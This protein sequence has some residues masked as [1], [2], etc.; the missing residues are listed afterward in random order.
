MLRIVAVHFPLFIL[1]A[2]GG[3]GGGG[4]GGATGPTVSTGSFPLRAGHSALTSAGA[5]DNFTVSGTCAGTS[6]IT[7]SPATPANFEGIAGFAATTTATINFTNCT[8]ASSA[9]SSVTFYDVNYTVLGSSTPGQEYS[10]FQTLPPPLPAS[11]RV[12]D[13]A[14][15]GTLIRYTDSSKAVITGTTLRSYVVEPD[16]ADTAVINFIAKDYN[17][18]SQLLFTQQT[19]YRIFATGTLTVLSIDIQFTTT[20]TTHLVLTKS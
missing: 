19:R 1:I 15:Y 2:C 8:P 6:T 4:G 14:T 18:A 3:G 20:S 17:N 7:D 9:A 10:K 13:T 12:G 11:I 16:T 5:T